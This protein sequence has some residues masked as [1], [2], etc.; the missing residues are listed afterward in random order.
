MTGD[1]HEGRARQFVTNI[2]V[3]DGLDHAAL[4]A[5]TRECRPRT[6]GK[7]AFYFHEG[8][9]GESCYA[10]QEG[11]VKLTQVAPDGHEVVL[12]II[13]PGALFGGVAAF[14][15]RTYP[16]SAQAMT[17]TR[18]L[19]WSGQALRSLMEEHPRIA[20][21]A[22]KYVASRLYESQDRIRELAT[23]RVEQRIARSLVRLLNQSGRRIE[24]GVLLDLPLSRQDLAEMT[25]TTL[26][27]VSRILTRW[28]QEGVVKSQRQ[29]IVVTSPHRLMALAED[30]P[31]AS[32]SPEAPLD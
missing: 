31:A 15:D 21:N 32:D 9:E 10:L 28:E 1:T 3:F 12:Q 17:E 29:R 4:Q 18:S 13:V 11:R 20:L 6:V 25:G 16:V 30:L 23:E 27:T 26:Y 8:D 22:L 14:S 19:R 7:D 24:G 5:V 2:D